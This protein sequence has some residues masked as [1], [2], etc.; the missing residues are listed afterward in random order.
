MLSTGVIGVRLPV[1][2]VLAGARAAAGS[3]SPEGGDAAAG[4]ILTTDSGPK[5]AASHRRTGS[6]SAAWQRAPG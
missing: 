5:L 6:P 2:K 3:L 1:D 4:A